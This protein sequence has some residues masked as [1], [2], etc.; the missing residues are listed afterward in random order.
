MELVDL[1][2]DF[3]NQVVELRK[4]ILMSVKAKQLNG[5]EINGKQY[6]D[7]ISSYVEAINSGE[8]PT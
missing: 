5:I 4:N 7:L 2:E 3:R 6:I 8:V 1:R